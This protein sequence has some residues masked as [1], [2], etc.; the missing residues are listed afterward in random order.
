MA[1]VLDTVAKAGLSRGTSANA[2]LQ[3][4]S[5]GLETHGIRGGML[6]DLGCGT[7]D[8]WRALA[9]RFDDYLGVDAVRYADFPA[10]ASLMEADLN[11]DC[12]EVGDAAADVVASVETIEHLENPRAFVRTAARIVKPGGWIVITTP[13][14]LS[15]LSKVSLLLSNQFPAFKERPGLYPSHI[16]ALLAVDLV[17]IATEAG[18][19]DLTIS[20]SEQGRI[21]SM[22]RHWP[23]WLSR[24][25][26][27][28]F[29]D[30]VLLF[31]RKPSDRRPA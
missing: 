23:R 13:N 11:G 16:T 20:Y 22:S 29:S 18:L 12:S 14:Q 27:Q 5:N 7:G 15:L 3:Q 24:W 28:S 6:V 26:P 30:N 17:R 31:A 21:P 19:V 25:M 4:V 1:A 8:L 2:I 9:E 10:A